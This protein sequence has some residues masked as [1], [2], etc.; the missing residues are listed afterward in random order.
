M[1]LYSVR[2][3]CSA[4]WMLQPPCTLSARIT[5]RLALRSNWYSVS[6]SVCE[7]ATTIESPVCTPTGSTFSMLQTMMQLSARSRRISYSTSFQPS[8]EVST[9]AWWITEAANPVASVSRSSASS[10]T[11]PPPVPPSV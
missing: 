6:E 5:L 7:G 11:T 8:S 3:G 4:N 2:S 9:S 1:M 10:R